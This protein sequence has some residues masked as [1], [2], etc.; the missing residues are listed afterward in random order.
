MKALLKK[1]IVLPDKSENTYDFIVADNALQKPCKGT[2]LSAG[3][4]CVAVKDGMR[5]VYGKQAGIE[6]EYNG[7]TYLIM[8]EQD[9]YITI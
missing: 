2:V 1:V 7:E 4:E 8:N 9:I 6:M 5:V 3:E